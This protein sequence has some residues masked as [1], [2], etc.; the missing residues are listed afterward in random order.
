MLCVPCHQHL[1]Q[2]Q[3]ACSI[4]SVHQNREH[5]ALAAVLE[6]TAV[7]VLAPCSQSVALSPPPDFLSAEAAKSLVSVTLADPFPGVPLPGYSWESSP[8]CS[9]RGWVRMGSHSAASLP[10]HVWIAAGVVECKSLISWVSGPC[11]ILFSFSP[12]AALFHW[13]IGK[14]LSVSY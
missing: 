3:A 11:N 13:V 4:L 5:P 12:R 10:C 6:R 9:T 7:L 1:P 8:T 2:P 14:Y